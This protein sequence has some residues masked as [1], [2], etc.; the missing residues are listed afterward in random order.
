MPPLHRQKIIAI[1]LNLNS[2]TV[3]EVRMKSNVIQIEN[4]VTKPLS[5]LFTNE[6]VFPLT[7]G[8]L[9]AVGE[10]TGNMDEMLASIA[11]YYEEEFTAVVDGLSTIIKPL[12][13]V[14]VGAMIGIIVVVLYLPIFSAGDAIR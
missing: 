13:I 3:A 2:L 10:H 9:M 6:K 14:L 5:V 11:K 12:T 7:L 1:K 8:Q 4:V